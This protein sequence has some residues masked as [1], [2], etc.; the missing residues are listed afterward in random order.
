[1]RSGCRDAVPKATERQEWENKTN[2]GTGNVA[3][4]FEYR[5]P[6]KQP[7]QQRQRHKEEQTAD[8]GG[9]AFPAFEAYKKRKAV[10]D[11]GAD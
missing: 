8:E 7:R 2:W 9:D 3:R 5:Q 11:Q 1:M 4:V 6:N 10:T